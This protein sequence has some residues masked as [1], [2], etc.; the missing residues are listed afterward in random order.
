[1]CLAVHQASGLCTPSC[2]L[3]NEFFRDDQSP[4]LP[5]VPSPVLVRVNQRHPD[6][7]TK[8]RSDT[9]TAPPT[10]EIIHLRLASPPPPPARSHLQP[11]PCNPSLARTLQGWGIAAPDIQS[12]PSHKR[13]TLRARCRSNLTKWHPGIATGW[14]LTQ[15]PVTASTAT[16]STATASTATAY[17]ATA[18]TATTYIV[19]AYTAT[20][21]PCLPF[22]N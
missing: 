1:V 21:S 5:P 3:L 19:T 6:Y 22:V 11:C 9:A 4:T 8:A 13:S 20:T 17:T 16:A 15:L 10:T 7:Y 12:E 18:Y 14:T 2:G